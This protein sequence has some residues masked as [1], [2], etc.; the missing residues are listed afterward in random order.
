MRASWVRVLWGY[1]AM[2][3]VGAIAAA[4]GA[5][6]TAEQSFLAL[7][8]QAEDNA[9]VAT[10]R[11]DPPSGSHSNADAACAA[12]ADAG[13]DFSKLTG[14]P[15]TLCPDI[16]DPVTAQARGQYRG[17]PVAFQQTYPNRCD[18]DRQTAPVFQF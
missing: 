9:S 6:A 16:F 4:P 15:G 12:L 8:V 2:M 11:C 7:S 5:S 13:G 17:A 10:L 18:L 1:A 14:Q 3:S